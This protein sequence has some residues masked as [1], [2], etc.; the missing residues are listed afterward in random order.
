VTHSGPS[1]TIPFIAPSKV[2]WSDS[3]FDPLPCEAI[4]QLLIAS[5]LRAFE[6]IMGKRE[7][8][9]V[10]GSG[11]YKFRPFEPKGPLLR[12]LP[13]SSGHRLLCILC[14]LVLSASS[15]VYVPQYP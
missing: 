11:Q 13:T 4:Y 6:K 8:C 3:L 5:Y 15:T 7:R 1:A 12:M 2:N 14:S 10:G 9:L